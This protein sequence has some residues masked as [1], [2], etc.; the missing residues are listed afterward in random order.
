MVC[1]MDLFFKNMLTGNIGGLTIVPLTIFSFI[2]YARGNCI[3]LA[4]AYAG[5]IP[6][7]GMG[8]DGFAT[9]GLAIFGNRDFTSTRRG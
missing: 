5:I 8:V 7:G 6:I 4:T 3:G 9:I 1:I 2:D